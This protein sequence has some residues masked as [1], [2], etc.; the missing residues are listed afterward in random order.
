MCGVTGYINLNG[1]P[2]SEFVLNNM[3]DLIAHRGPDDSGCFVSG[4]LGLGHARLSIIDLS[5]AG[6]Q[7]METKDKR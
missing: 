2:A 6:R 5:K 4:A 1:V 7:P 3:I